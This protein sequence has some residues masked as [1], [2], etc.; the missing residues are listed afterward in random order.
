MLGWQHFLSSPKYL[1]SDVE[2]SECTLHEKLS[3]VENHLN[4][5]L[6]RHISTQN[7]EPTATTEK[8][9]RIRRE[10]PLLDVSQN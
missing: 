1:F 5:F 2:L 10:A 9:T 6:E 7:R 4:Y 3:L 8:Q